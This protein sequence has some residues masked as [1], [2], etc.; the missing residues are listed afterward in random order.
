MPWLDVWRRALWAMKAHGTWGPEMRPLL[1]EYVLA[2]RAATEAREGFAWLDHLEGVASDDVDWVVLGKIA[3][4]LPTQWDRHAR[5]ASALADQLGL[6]PRGRQK[7]RAS[8]GDGD[9]KPADPFAEVDELA[10][11][12][13][14]RT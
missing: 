12:R 1:D 8:G 9:S 14:A 6:T 3:G 2:L 5:R 7:V 10:R 11:K 4:G 13:A